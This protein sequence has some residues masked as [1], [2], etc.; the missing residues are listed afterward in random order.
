LLE[1]VAAFFEEGRLT[2]GAEYYKPRK[3]RLPDLFVSPG[4]LDRALELLNGLLLSLEDRGFWVALSPTDRDYRRPRLNAREPPRSKEYLWDEWWP[5]GPT[6]AFFGTVAIGLTLYEVIESAEVVSIGGKK[7]R[8]SDAPPRHRSGYSYRS[9]VPSGRLGL[10]AYSP[11]E[12]TSWERKWLE[13]RPGDFAGQLETICRGL[14]AAAPEIAEQVLDAEHEAAIRMRRWEEECRESL[15][16][17]QERRQEQER[18]ER[19]RRR[20]EAFGKSRAAFLSI[21][22]EWATACRVESFA[23]DVTRRIPALDPEEAR[24]LAD[25]LD[26]ARNLLGATNALQRLRSWKTPEEILS[27]HP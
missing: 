5:S 25:R 2:Y 18:R 1:S 27:D 19:E 12:G 21:L 23:Q 10:R 9:D 8:V 3:R 13:K 6:V 16:R 20:P 11:Y 24:S 26:Q 4:A 14:Q 7:V 22:D 15:R 17:E